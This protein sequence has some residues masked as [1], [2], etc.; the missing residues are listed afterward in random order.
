MESLSRSSWNHCPVWRGIRSF[1]FFQPIAVYRVTTGLNQGILHRLAAMSVSVVPLLSLIV[2]IPLKL[3]AQDAVDSGVTVQVRGGSEG[4]FSL[5]EEVPRYFLF[6]HYKLWAWLIALLACIYGIDAIHIHSQNQ[7]LSLSVAEFSLR[8]KIGSRY[9]S[10]EDGRFGH[11]YVETTHQKK[12]EPSTAKPGGTVWVL[13]SVEE[14]LKE[15]TTAKPGVSIV[16]KFD[17]DIS[18]SELRDKLRRYHEGK[19]PL[20]GITSRDVLASLGSRDREL[21]EEHYQLPASPLI[22]SAWKKPDDYLSARTAYLFVLIGSLIV[23][24]GTLKYFLAVRVHYLGYARRSEDTDTNLLVAPASQGLG[25]KYLV[26]KLSAL[27]AIEPLAPWALLFKAKVLFMT[28]AISAPLR[29]I[30]A[31]FHA[32]REGGAMA[33]L[34]QMF[35]QNKTIHFYASFGLATFLLERGDI[36]GNSAI[37]NL[38]LA[39]MGISFVVWLVYGQLGFARA[40]LLAWATTFGLRYLVYEYIPGVYAEGF[41]LASLEWIG[42]AGV[43]IQIDLLNAPAYPFYTAISYLV[44]C[45]VAWFCIALVSGR[46]SQAIPPLIVRQA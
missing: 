10:L 39:A 32:L 31:F 1:L 7:L 42:F 24:Y 46:T 44:A 13:L 20:T 18:Q 41:A 27:D 30:K 43:F 40:L 37:F 3:R 21:L 19:L 38:Q 28:H 25:N 36:L 16:V 22:L 29:V 45:Y 23:L 5:P 35:T 8:D 4:I 34:G 12:G 33:L 11:H 9:L 6:T 26:L 2:L 15:G 14:F 17:G